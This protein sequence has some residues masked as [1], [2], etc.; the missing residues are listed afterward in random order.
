[1]TE[2]QEYTIQGLK[3]LKGQEPW[4]CDIHYKLFNEDHYLIGY[5][6]CEQWIKTHNLN[7]FDIIREVKFYEI[8]MFGEFL[9]DVSNSEKLV[10]MYVYI[11]GEEILNKSKHLMEVWDNHLTDKDLKTIINE[12]S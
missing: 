1:M 2:L 3:D 7:V 5:Y 10:N 12:L 9:T 6:N 11:K 4:G 8:E